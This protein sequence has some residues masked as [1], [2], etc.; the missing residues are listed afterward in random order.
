[1]A[2]WYGTSRSNYFRVK[3]EAA[4]RKFVDATGVECFVDNKHRFAVVADSVNDGNWP[5]NIYKQYEDGTEDYEDIAF[6]D[7]LAKHLADDEIAVLMTTGAEKLRY[8]TGV[9][10][11]IKNDGSY[12]EINIDD[13]Y[14][15]AFLKWGVKP[16]RAEY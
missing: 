5:S 4:F 12:V 10:V 15:V 1:M 11:A 3:D 2:N 7:E 8:V 14:D 16:S 9:A 13:I 6:I